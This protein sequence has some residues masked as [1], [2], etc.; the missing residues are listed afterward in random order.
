VVSNGLTT[1]VTSAG[2][3][4]FV[5][6]LSPINDLC[7]S[8][9]AWLLRGSAASLGGCTIQ[10]TPGSTTQAGSIVWPTLIAT[11]N[12]Q[13]S[14]TVTVKNT[15]VTPADGF[16]LVLADP[17]LGA[18]TSSLGLTGQGLGAKGIPGFVLGFDTYQ[19][20][21]LPAPGDPPVPYLGVGRG[22]TVLWENPWTNYNHNI[23]ALAVHNSV[24]THNYTVSLVQGQMTVTMD[25]AQVFSGLVRVP[26]VAYLMF[27]ASTGGSYEEHDIS[28]LSAILSAP[29]N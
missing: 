17:S 19:N 13:L 24:V 29:S 14:F 28:N 15:S 16:C 12:L 23:P 3:G 7:S 6:S 20:G 25:G 4:L 1:P 21:S 2:A 11:G 5:G 27:T 18:T 8:A 26:P 22:E 9:P 10:L